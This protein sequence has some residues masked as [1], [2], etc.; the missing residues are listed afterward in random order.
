MYPLLEFLSTLPQFHADRVRSEVVHIG[1]GCTL[2]RRDSC[3]PDVDTVLLA[4]WPGQP[5][6]DACAI[7]GLDAVNFYMREAR[8][9]G[10]E[11][12]LLNRAIGVLDRS[13]GGDT[14]FSKSIYVLPARATEDDS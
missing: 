8:T 9:M 3:G 11:P 7:D 4:R 13:M 12:G 6:G 1:T 5:P 10:A 2:S 14:L